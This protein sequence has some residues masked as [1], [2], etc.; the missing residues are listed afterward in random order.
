MKA[1]IAYVSD[2]NLAQLPQSAD[3]FSPDLV[4]DVQLGQ[5]HLRRAEQRIFGGTHHG[6][7]RLVPPE[8]E[9]LCG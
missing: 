6:H 2:L 7:G 5:G 1:R 4:G 3:N 9:M 8:T